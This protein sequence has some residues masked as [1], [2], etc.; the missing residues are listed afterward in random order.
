MKRN[1]TK[2]I[3]VAL[4]MSITMSLMTTAVNVDAAKKIKLSK[5]SVTLAMGMS[6]T[7][8]IKNVKAKKIKK[9]T[10]KSSNKKIAAVKRNGNKKTSF[11]VTGKAKG[12]TKIQ[13]KLYLR[14]QKKSKKLTLKVK[15]K[16]KRNVPNVQPK[17]EATAS[18]IPNVDA[19]AS[20]QPN[21]T[22]GAQVTPMVHPTVLPTA[23]ATAGPTVVPVVTPGATGSSGETMAPAASGA[24]TA[25][26]TPTASGTPALKPTAVPVVTPEATGPAGETMK[27]IATVKPIVE[28]TAEPTSKPTATPVES[29][30]DTLQIESVMVTGN[31]KLSI[32]FNKPS[33]I[34]ADVL[35]IK[36]KKTEQDSYG[37]ALRI[38]S[39]KK[40]DPLQ[41]DVVLE[42]DAAAGNYIVNN[43]YVQVTVAGESGTPLVA[44]N[45]FE[46]E[47]V[48]TTRQWVQPFTF[49][50]ADNSFRRNLHN[51]NFVGEVQ[52]KVIGDMPD[53]M[54][55][56]LWDLDLYVGGTPEKAGI[57][58]YDL[59]IT[60]EAGNNLVYKCT[61]LMGDAKT[62]YAAAAAE[63]YILV[64]E[65][66][67]NFVR[68]SGGSGSYTY[69]NAGG[70]CNFTVASDGEVEVE[71]AEF[72]EAGTYQLYVDVADAAD[73]NL[74]TR[75]TVVYHVEGTCELR[76]SVRDL[77]GT[78]LYFRGGG[79]KIFVIPQDREIRYKYLSNKPRAKLAVLNSTF[80]M[81]VPAGIYDIQFENDY[82]SVYKVIKD[83][84]VSGEDVKCSL[85]TLGTISLPVCQVN[86]EAP[87]KD[88]LYE[89]DWRDEEGVLI[90]E[91]ETFPVR[92]GTYTIH[93]DPDTS[94]VMASLY[95]FKV[96]FTATNDTVRNVVVAAT[97]TGDRITE[98]TLEN[99]MAVSLAGHL[100][101]WYRFVPKETGKYQ[102]Y[103]TGLEKNMWFEIYSDKQYRN[104]DWH[105][106]TFSIDTLAY[107]NGNQ[108]N[109]PQTLD[110]GTT[111]YISLNLFWPDDKDDFVFGVKKVE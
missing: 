10:V 83:V 89:I 91:D 53:G 37:E 104:S 24:P 8:K 97:P 5:K 33:G 17:V 76:G 44:E 47:T 39:I 95:D 35:A 18:M 14:G 86:L 106:L 71:A 29:V 42:D 3:A 66:D 43:G 58:K 93:S 45:Q 88:N 74:K 72:K 99:D 6:S 100:S 103:S 78:G 15:V 51:E 101:K 63:Q 1:M 111:Y 57:Y 98:L 102:F 85:K 28:P 38:K 82:G 20:T 27:P 34:T 22:P 70:D 50:T 81:N 94:K 79:L 68:V 77:G 110:A 105:Y 4:S 64:G 61:S 19:T 11:K 109:Y 87:N 55:Y 23:K 30:P 54:R 48:T 31:H 67:N 21:I 108:V 96:S 46:C 32:F 41:Y 69:T 16:Q 7:I 65:T 49:G 107:K 73:A 84:E 92:P 36:T 59:S 26:E 60:D 13:V 40:V 52:C 75:V 62:L 90:G 56:S 9:L 25:S 80:H 12:S 2:A